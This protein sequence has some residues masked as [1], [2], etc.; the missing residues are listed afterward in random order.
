MRFQSWFPGR[1]LRFIL[2]LLV[3]FV[4]NFHEPLAATKLNMNEPSPHSFV[5]DAGF[6][7]DVDTAVAIA[8]AV[9]ARIYGKD[10]IEQQKPFLASLNGDTW[11]VV[12]S[13]QADRL[14]GA[15]EVQLSKTDGR[16]IRVTHGR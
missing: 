13:V 15:F 4:L 11:T 7:P 16:V 14:G 3:I 5:P 2:C 8:V 10:R 9:A 1:G 12:G 6:V